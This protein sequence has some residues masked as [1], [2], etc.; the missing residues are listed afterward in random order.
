MAAG[1]KRITLKVRVEAASPAS[2]SAS[3]RSGFGD[4]Q[5]QQEDVISADGTP[6]LAIMRH[7]LSI[8]MEH[9]GSQFPFLDLQSLDTALLAGNGSV[10]MFDCIAA[11]ASRCVLIVLYTSWS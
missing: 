4:V 6:N 9:F 1:L 8:F 7:L 11:I 2:A 3:I 5:Q 10:F